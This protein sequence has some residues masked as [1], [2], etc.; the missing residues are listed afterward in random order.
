MV[1]R[2][3]DFD[4]IVSSAVKRFQRRI[5]ADN[6]SLVW[7]LPYPTAELRNYEESFSAYYDEIEICDAAQNSHPKRAYQIRN[8]QMVDR[9]DLV[10]FYVEH[11][12]GGAYQTMQYAQG[13]GKRI[14]NLAEQPSEE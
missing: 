8:R 12:S 6:S 2:G 5:R 7:I 3:G 4:Q 11:N 9:S 10:V 14:I 1:G 13:K